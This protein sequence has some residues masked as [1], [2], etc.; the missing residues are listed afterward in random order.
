[1]KTQ[2]L[3]CVNKWNPPIGRAF[4]SKEESAPSFLFVKKSQKKQLG[5]E[6][7]KK[8]SALMGLGI[9]GIKI[10]EVCELEE[11]HD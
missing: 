4:F 11:E 1:M 7:E 6:I 8:I 9:A 5:K 10:S 3:L 2:N